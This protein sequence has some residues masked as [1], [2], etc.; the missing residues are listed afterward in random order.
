[1]NRDD[2][3]LIK[4]YEAYLKSGGKDVS[5]YAALFEAYLRKNDETKALSYIDQALK[6]Y[7]TNKELIGTKINYFTSNKKFDEALVA[8]Q[9]LI[10][11][12]PKSSEAHVN[13]GIIYDKKMGDNDDKIASLTK[14]LNV[15]KGLDEKIESKANQI[16]EYSIERNKLA[17]QLKKT[18]KNA[19][20]KNRL[21]NA[22]TFLKEQ[23]ANLEK[24]KAEKA[25]IQTT[26]ADK[27]KM[28]AE[29][30]DLK[31]QKNNNMNQAISWY[32]KG[33]NLDA[34]NA[35]AYYNL[36]VIYLNDAIEIKKPYDDMNPSSEDFKKNGKALE[37][38]FLARFKEA[39]P[40][41]EKSY[42]FRKDEVVKVSLE[43]IYRLLKLEDKLKKIA[44]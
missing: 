8:Y 21:A 41:L 44:E 18:P 26:A 12:D 15:G 28:Q 19:D 43:N 22:E 10:A 11:V 33:I 14:S 37:D 16:K 32:N 29:L 39:M 20:I 31:S 7:P 35:D 25:A 30:S 13:I 24:L 3:G 36:G 2:N 6:L 4:G 27:V 34:N 1:M 9:E 17:D 23:T 40:Y 5:T 42:D 38:K